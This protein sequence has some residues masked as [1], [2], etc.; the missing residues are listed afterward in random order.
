MVLGPLVKIFGDD[1]VRKRAQAGNFDFD[2]VADLHF[3]PTPAEE[4]RRMMPSHFAIEVEDWDGFLAYLTE[5]GVRYT[6]P[7]ERPQNQ[8][9]LCYITDP[10]GTVIEITY[11]GKLHVETSVKV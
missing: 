7:I 1:R 6:Q 11:H 9:K 2:Q 8:S 5:I 10:D 3:T 4:W